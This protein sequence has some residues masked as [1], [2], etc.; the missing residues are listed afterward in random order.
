V[1]RVTSQTGLSQ[2]YVVVVSMD[3][4]YYY[5]KA[6][7][8]DSWP[9]VYSGGS[10]SQPFKTLA[11]AVYRASIHDKINKI[12]VIGEL[13]DNT[14]GG[15]WEKTSVL[16]DEF[17]SSGGE[18]GSVFNLIGTKGKTITVTGV[19]NATLRGASG[20]RVLSVTGGADLIFENI[21][22]TGGNTNNGNGG[23]IYISGNSGVKFSG[24][25]I[26]GNSARSG[27]G[28]YAESDRNDHY[29][30]TLVTGS[31]TG[32]TATG[33]ATG[34]VAGTPIAGGGGIYTNGH[35][36]VWLAGGTVSGNTTAGSGGGILINGMAYGHT[37][38]LT[39]RGDEYGLL[40]S[41]GTI[42]NNKSSGNVS[43]HGGGG[44]YV[45]KGVFE[46]LAGSISGNN[47]TRQGG[48]VFVWHNARFTASGTSSITGN[49]GTGSSK[50][51]C[52]RGYTEMM[53]RAQADKIYIWNNNDDTPAFNSERDSF[54]LAEN[55][56]AAGI[57][58]AYD[59]TNDSTRQTR[60]FVRFV[61]TSPAGTDQ[62]CL[63][64][65]EGHLTNYQ[66]K[67]TNLNDWIGKDGNGDDI[68]I[69]EVDA[70]T[71]EATV[72][73]RFPLNTFVGGTTLTLKGKYL[74]KTIGYTPVH[75][76]STP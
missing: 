71:S 47:S 53:G 45:A 26:T 21:T 57:V 34:T 25:S 67:D 33:T 66:F 23:G 5:V 37:L 60:N 2:D 69:L 76:S 55:A 46:M 70:S 13:N 19:S 73:Q 44:V 27:G 72:R 39:K 24:G 63:I 4:Q 1:Y 65:L 64:D 8:S 52:S 32:N 17:Q 9:D 49:D 18:P 51:I 20:K 62:V 74:K 40:M 59:D 30:F 6:T 75:L 15:A 16:P 38:D 54:T 36:L 58:L 31:I 43:P 35:A 7:G 12:F 68:K 48:G 50:G 10:E 11:Y 42:S 28:V 41:G 29:D 22:I 14:E 56:R 3:V 61:D